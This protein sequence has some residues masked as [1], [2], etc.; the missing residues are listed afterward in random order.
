M[1]ELAEYVTNTGTVRPGQLYRDA[2]PTN[3]RTLRV[4]SIDEL[5]I[6]CTVIRQEY[7]GEVTTPNR[8][9]KMTARRLTGRAFVLIGSVG[10]AEL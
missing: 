2:R 4:D 3:V 5:E 1:P 6:A 7:E 10:E 8:V 9:T